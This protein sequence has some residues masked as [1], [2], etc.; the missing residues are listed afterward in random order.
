MVKFWTSVARRP[1]KL[2]SVN[3]RSMVDM[4]LIGKIMAGMPKMA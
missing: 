4:S 1:N 3:L 2:L